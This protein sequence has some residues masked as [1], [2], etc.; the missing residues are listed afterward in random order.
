MLT[1][2]LLVIGAI[3]LVQLLSVVVAVRIMERRD[4]YS[5]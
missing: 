3:P 4:Y 1:L 2:M 5:S